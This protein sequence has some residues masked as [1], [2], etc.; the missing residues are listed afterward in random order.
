MFNFPNT[1]QN[2]QHLQWEK[3]PLSADSFP[4]FV[5]AGDRISCEAVRGRGL[6]GII[7]D[8]PFSIIIVVE[9]VNLVFYLSTGFIFGTF[10][11]VPS[12]P[13]LP[14]FKNFYLVV[15]RRHKVK[16]S[17]PPALTTK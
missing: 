17:Y 3:N 1:G 4:C 15:F 14:C 13:F 10:V 8:M 2:H 7:S 5:S 9:T 12:L 6:G 11:F 16:K